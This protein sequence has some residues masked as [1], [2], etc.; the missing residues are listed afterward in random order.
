[1]VEKKSETKLLHV[2]PADI[3]RTS[4]AMIT[5]ELAAM[6]KE[7]PQKYEEIIKRVIH[8][9]ADF[10]YADTL[11]F[12]DG[13]KEILY[14]ALRRGAHIV[15]DTNMVLAG[16]NKKAL[17]L[18]GGEAHCFMAEPEV[19]QEAKRRGCTRASVSMEKAAALEEPVIF[20]VGN[21]P[22]ALIRLYEMMQE[23]FRPVAVIG[24]PVGFVNVEAAKELI[25][26]SGVPC[27]VNRGRK[28][29]S[30]VAAAICNALL[31]GLEKEKK[32][33]WGYTTGS[34]AA[35]A[36]KAAAEMLFSDKTVYQVRLETPKGYAVTLETED[37]TRDTDWVSCAVR[38]DAGDDPDIT[39]GILV[40]AR[41]E[42]TGK[43]ASGILIDGGKGVGRITKPGLDQPVG[44]AAINSVPREMIEKEVRQVCGA[45]DYE[46]SLSVEISIPEGVR[47]AEKTFN[48]R[49]GIV[50]GISVLGTTGIVEPMSNQALLDTIQVELQ[51]KKAEGN[52]VLCITP[53]NYGQAFLK[54]EHGIELDAA[55]KCSNFAGE[56]IKMAAKLGFQKILFTGHLGKL[57]KIAAGSMNTHSCYGDG[58]ME[59]L[60]KL[61]GKQGAKEALCREI[62]ACVSTEEAVEIL[63]RQEIDKA[64]FSEAAGLVKQN[65]ERGGRQISE[66]FQVEVLL[67]STKYGL[68]SET[69]GAQ[70]MISEWR[71][72]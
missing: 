5:E 18:L 48:P 43:E 46:G 51:V 64:V 16:I 4:F 72:V 42:K 54:Q 49:L 61:A 26:D 3:E 2:E 63:K 41:V 68:L 13:V 8:T 37:I 71:K 60:G 69:A 65:L 30:N 28:G 45:F 22:T 33:A 31:Y 59:M 29:G 9:T 67:F 39:D 34:C 62:E 55:V 38:K 57:I 19:A 21:A 32:P 23:D 35:A 50:G 12:S 15:T 25:I 10:E 40:Y 6:G 14:R 52:T 11:Y 24:V 7:I 53:G 20:A 44:A 47:L 70:E 58:R 17:A 36:A 56:T 66:E 27:I 1:M